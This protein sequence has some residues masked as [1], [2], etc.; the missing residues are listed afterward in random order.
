M[1]AGI[2]EDTHNRS[3][4]EA[5]G[6]GAERIVDAT[7]RGLRY[8]ATSVPYQAFIRRD[9]ERALRI[10]ASKAA[11]VQSRTI[12]LNQRLIEEEMRTGALRLPVDAHTMAYAL[13]RI[14]ESFLYAD[15]IAGEEPDLDK[16]VE[17][18]KLMLR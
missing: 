5:K 8:I 16:A 6:K 9:P 12:A 1:I 7:A 3:V 4:R 14:G 2:V 10:V 13:V 18:L 11:P 17:I 15:A